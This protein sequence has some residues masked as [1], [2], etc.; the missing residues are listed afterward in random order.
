MSQEGQEAGA[1]TH[2]RRCG[3]GGE[4]RRF[5]RRGRGEGYC[6][7]PAPPVQAPPLPPLPQP[8]LLP[9]L[10][11][12]DITPP[13]LHPI[14]AHLPRSE[15]LAALLPAQRVIIGVRLHPFVHGAPACA[16]G[17]QGRWRGKKELGLGPLLLGHNGLQF[18]LPLLSLLLL[19]FLLPR[20]GSGT[21]RRSVSFPYPSPSRQAGAHLHFCPWRVPRSFLVHSGV[22]LGPSNAPPTTHTDTAHTPPWF[23]W[24][25]P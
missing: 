25:E 2:Q 17:E 24:E 11:H 5:A 6:R 15:H 14:P 1:W 16:R 13:P 7:R 4:K 8:P 23:T 3:G 12:L 22:S 18:L 10:E 19:Q 21:K 9:P 20:M